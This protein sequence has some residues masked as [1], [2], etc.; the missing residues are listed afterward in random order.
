MKARE[1][2]NKKHDNTVLIILGVLV[3]T[4]ALA[5]LG[6]FLRKRKLERDSILRQ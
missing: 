3:A 4:I 5:C 1:E 6:R 2:E